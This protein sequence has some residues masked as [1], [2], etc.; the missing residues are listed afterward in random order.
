MIPETHEAF[1]RMRPE[2]L[3]GRP[4]LVDLSETNAYSSLAFLSPRPLLR[5]GRVHRCHLAQAW[6][7]LWGLPEGHS[8]R[9]LICEGVRSALA[10]IGGRLAESGESILIPSDVYPAYARI[11]SEAGTS[12]SIAEMGRGLR[13][14]PLGPHRFL[15][16]CEPSKP[17]GFPAGREELELVLSWLSE[18]RERRVVI[19]AVYADP[20]RPT[21][22]LS[23]FLRHPQA[24]VLHSLSKGWLSPRI[25]GVALV[26][27]SDADRFSSSFRGASP[28][29]S[30][31]AMGEAL[32]NDFPD[33]PSLVR[34][35]AEEA[36]LRADDLL[37]SLGF[38]MPGHGARDRGGIVYLRTLDVPWTVLLER[39]ALALP[40]IVFGGSPASSVISSLP[41]AFR[42]AAV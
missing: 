36:N 32:L 10:L 19:D 30:S 37:A 22:A 25:L 41:S 14:A 23:T 16:L 18:D 15:L 28:S 13:S 4:G 2:L 31:L 40:A 8:G 17:R 6:L 38:R 11:L 39:G 7:R 1:V 20:S 5:E 34:A 33:R 26:P 29:A 42:A 12:F 24:I 9:A 35:F 3:A 21:E 27:E